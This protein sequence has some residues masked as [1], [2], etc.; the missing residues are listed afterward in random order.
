M[1]KWSASCWCVAVFHGAVG[2]VS[3]QVLPVDM[4]NGCASLAIVSTASLCCIRYHLLLTHRSSEQATLQHAL[5]TSL[6][7]LA[8]VA[9]D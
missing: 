7:Y 2:P 5:H 4:S 8:L 1:C 6:L 3:D 9:C